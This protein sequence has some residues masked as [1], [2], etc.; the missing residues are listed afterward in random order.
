MQT[1]LTNHGNQQPP[2]HA[3]APANGVTVLVHIYYPGSW[4]IISQK[5]AP[6]LRMASAIIVTVCHDDVMQE[7]PRAHN[8]IILKVPNKGK[9]IGGKLAA[10][11][12]YINFCTKTPYITFLHDKISP[13]SINADYWSDQLYSIFSEKLFQKALHSLHSNRTKGI[14]GAQA[15]VKNEYSPSRK[16]F[17]G[18]NDKM[19]RGLMADYGLSCKACNFIAGTIFIA[20]SQIFEYFFSKFSALA[21]R[22]KLETGNVLDL[23]GGT[24][25]HSW[26]R[27]LCFIAED[28]GYTVSGIS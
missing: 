25:T 27:L 28:Q 14:V 7:I 22:E 11:A 13:Q 5:C 4:A 9:D 19:L 15:F 24:Y 16:V 20:K 1:G 8:L 23:E 12:Y 6:L 26:E 10:M 3:A 17:V 18:N 21:A 2:N